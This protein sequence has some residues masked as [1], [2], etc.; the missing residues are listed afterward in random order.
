MSSLHEFI[1]LFG[2]HRY[3]VLMQREGQY[4]GEIDCLCKSLEDGKY[5]TIVGYSSITNNYRSRKQHGK[6]D[7]RGVRAAKQEFMYNNE[8][9]L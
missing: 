7:A 1:N 5:Y 2:R 3:K 6:L 9:T 8:Q 4:K